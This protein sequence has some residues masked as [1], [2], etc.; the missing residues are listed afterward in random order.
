MGINL[1]ACMVRRLPRFT[2][3]DWEKADTKEVGEKTELSCQVAG[4]VCSAFSLASPH[5][6]QKG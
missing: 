2:F 1:E 3:Y 6:L 4:E 5:G